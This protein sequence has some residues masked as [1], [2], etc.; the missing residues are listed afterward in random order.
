[1]VAASESGSNAPRL[2]DR[3]DS[4]DLCVVLSGR[5]VILVRGGAPGAERE[6]EVANLGPDKV[7]GELALI[8]GSPR[9][10]TVR[11]KGGPLRVLRIP[12]QTF[13]DRLLPRGR[14]PPSLLLTLT[15]RLRAL[16]SQLSETAA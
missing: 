8:D 10:A 3:P 5:A 9:S 15:P 6:S 14:V 12:A 13:R 7:V 1:M 11:P 2:E 16:A 4:S